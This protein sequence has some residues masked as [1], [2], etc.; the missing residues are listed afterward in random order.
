MRSNRIERAKPSKV[1]KYDIIL[2][3]YLAN[4]WQTRKTSLIPQEKWLLHHANDMKVKYGEDSMI[5]P[6]P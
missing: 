6:K 4:M 3:Y 5:Q 2:C 1:T